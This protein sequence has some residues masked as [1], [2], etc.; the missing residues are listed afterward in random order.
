MWNYSVIT[1][2]LV[3]ITVILCI[4]A[5]IVFAAGRRVKKRVKIVLSIL[6]L[7]SVIAVIVPF[8]LANRPRD[9]VLSERLN[10]EALSFVHRASTS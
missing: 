3:P 5:L 10:R 8:R 7:L 2:F 4:I 1:V 6:A 9:P